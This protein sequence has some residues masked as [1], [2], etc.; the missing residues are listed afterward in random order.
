M[1]GLRV[2]DL[3]RVLAGPLCTQMLADHGADVDQGRAAARATR[4]AVSARRSM[5]AGRGGVFH[6][7]VNRGK[8]GI[9]LDLS[10]PKGARVL[11]ALLEGCRRA[12]G[13]FPARHDGAL[14]ARLRGTLAAAPSAPD[15]LRHLRLRRRRA[16][17]RAAGLRR[18]AAGDVRA[19]EHQRHAGV[20]RHPGWHSDRRLPHGLQCADRHSAGAGGARNGP[21]GDSASR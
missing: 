13:E 7:A 5:T 10:R 18:G 1:T 9:A 6:G 14:G 21:E 20:G 17:G 3:S 16:V 8:R 11:E 12:G 4:R 15:L 19:D 2:V